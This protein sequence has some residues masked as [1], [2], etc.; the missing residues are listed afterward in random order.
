MEGLYRNEVD[1]TRERNVKEGHLPLTGRAGR[2]TMQVPLLLGDREDPC[3]RIPH[4]CWPENSPLTGEHF[5]GR[6]E[7]QLGYGSP[8]FGDLA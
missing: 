2:L 8:K 4:W 6:L 3:D 1:K 5:W 7:L